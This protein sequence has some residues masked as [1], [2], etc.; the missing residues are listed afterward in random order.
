[1]IFLIVLLTNAGKEVVPPEIFPFDPNKWTVVNWIKSR[2][3]PLLMPGAC[4]GCLMSNHN[5]RKETAGAQ[6]SVGCLV[7]WH[8]H[9]EPWAARGLVLLVRSLTQKHISLQQQQQRMELLNNSGHLKTVSQM[10]YHNE[11]ASSESAWGM[12]LMIA[13]VIKYCGPQEG[14]K[15]VRTVLIS[16]I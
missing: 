1:M 6:H 15:L 14:Q 3:W 8:Q 4:T 13:V 5:D 7:I 10:K 9:Y 12:W 11:K 16:F 2:Y